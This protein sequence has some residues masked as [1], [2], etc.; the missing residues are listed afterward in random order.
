MLENKFFPSVYIQFNAND[1]SQ[2][3]NGITLSITSDWEV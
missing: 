3:M 1:S 2:Q